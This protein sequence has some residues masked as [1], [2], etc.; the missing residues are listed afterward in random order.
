MGKLEGDRYLQKIITP[1]VN[2]ASLEILQ[3]KGLALKDDEVEFFFFA[4]IAAFHFISSFPLH[5]ALYIHILWGFF[6]F[7]VLQPGLNRYTL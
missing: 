3:E 6:F 7:L 4:V 1:V 2:C 5:I